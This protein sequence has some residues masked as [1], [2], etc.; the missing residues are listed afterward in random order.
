MTPWLELFTEEDLEVMEYASDL[1]VL[2]MMTSS[3]SLFRERC[4][5]YNNKKYT[6]DFHFEN[7]ITID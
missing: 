5:I 1:K 4:K 2:P 7:C 6:S 3:T